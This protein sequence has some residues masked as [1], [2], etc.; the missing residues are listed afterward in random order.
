MC[1]PIHT[2]TLHIQGHNLLFLKIVDFKYLAW[3]VSLAQNKVCYILNWPVPP[4]TGLCCLSVII[5]IQNIV[6]WSSCSKNLK[7]QTTGLKFWIS[8]SNPKFWNP[9][10]LSNLEDNQESGKNHTWKF[11]GRWHDPSHHW[12]NKQQHFPVNFCSTANNHLKD[13]LFVG[14][15]LTG[16]ETSLALYLVFVSLKCLQ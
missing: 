1:N 8:T 13:T 4:N 11:M 6:Y 10:F 15:I 7:S 12:S 16:E 5:Y 3:S 14:H 2:I 9:K